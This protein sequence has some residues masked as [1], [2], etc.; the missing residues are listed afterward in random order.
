MVSQTDATNAVDMGDNYK[1]S[2]IWAELTEGGNATM[3]LAD[4]EQARKTAAFAKMRAA[5]DG[6]DD[7]FIIDLLM[8]GISVP[9]EMMKQPM[10]LGQ[11]TG[12]FAFAQR[13]AT[14]SG[15]LDDT[16]TNGFV[17]L[18]YRVRAPRTSVWWYCD[19]NARN[20]ARTIVGTQKGLLFVHNRHRQFT[21]CVTGQPRP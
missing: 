17:Q 5:Y 3:S 11:Q 12:M 2:E 20:S 14:D 1:L 16:A 6:I 7:E 15:N 21:K 8:Q 10:L 4:I 9:T 19:D 18:G 13:Y